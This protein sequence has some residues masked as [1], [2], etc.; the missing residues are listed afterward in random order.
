[1]VVVISFAVNQFSHAQPPMEWFHNYQLF[2]AVVV[3]VVL[4]G[5][6]IALA[7]K[8]AMLRERLQMLEQ[9][10]SA[11]ATIWKTQ[12]RTGEPDATPEVGACINELQQTLLRRAN[13]SGR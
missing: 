5:I 2:A 10:S 6:A 11:M 1:M 13:D 7:L 4:G 12:L 8:E 9:L 3:F